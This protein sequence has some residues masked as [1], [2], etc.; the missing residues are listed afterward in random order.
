MGTAVSSIG[1]VEWNDAAATALKR[2]P[3]VLTRT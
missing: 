3:R 1:T 2:L